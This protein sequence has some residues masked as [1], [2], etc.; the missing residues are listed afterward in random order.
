MLKPVKPYAQQRAGLPGGTALHHCENLKE[1]K[2]LLKMMVEEV[3]FEP[4]YPD[5]SRFTV[6]RL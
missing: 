4:T 1:I 3:G 6:C 5:G 2:G